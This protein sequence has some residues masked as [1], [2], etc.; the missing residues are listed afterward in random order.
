LLERQLHA[1]ATIEEC[2][3]A[4]ENAAHSL[5]YSHMTARLGDVRFSTQPRGPREHAHWQMRLNLAPDI[6]INI[7]QR[8][9]GSEQPVLLVPFADALRRSLPAKLSALADQSSLNSRTTTVI[10]SDCVAPPANIATAS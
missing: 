4:L 3:L 8:P 2:W 5:G 9:G 7:T 1:A 6:W 10:S